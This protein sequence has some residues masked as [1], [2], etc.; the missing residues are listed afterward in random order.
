MT[1][2]KEIRDCTELQKKFVDLWLMNK[3]RDQRECAIKAGYS[4]KSAEA[5]ASQLL[6][7]PIVINYINERTKDIE[8][9]LRK[10]FIFEAKEALEVM[11]TLMH[12][13]EVNANVRYNVC[14]DFLDRAGYK[15]VEKVE[16][17]V[18]KMPTIKIT[19]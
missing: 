9:E 15:A 13:E 10:R 8:D 4:P 19:K 12:D 14:K 18:T 7:N 16:L 11:T 1:K 6:K 17:E 5:Q 3:R 2:K